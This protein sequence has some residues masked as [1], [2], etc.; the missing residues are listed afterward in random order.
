[1]TVD[2]PRPHAD[3]RHLVRVGVRVRVS[4]R[5][6]VRVRAR[7]RVRVGHVAPRAGAARLPRSPTEGRWL[8]TARGSG[9]CPTTWV[10]R[11]VITR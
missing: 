1:M 3:P 4:F 6:R 9:A 8:R 5:V 10:V 11:W 7:V 2:T